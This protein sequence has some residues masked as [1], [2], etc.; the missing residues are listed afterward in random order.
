MVLLFY[1]ECSLLK[2][3]LSTVPLLP[4]AAQETLHS[5]RCEKVLDLGGNL[6]H[7]RQRRIHPRSIRYRSRQ[8]SLDQGS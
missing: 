2:A 4:L 5:L 8:I 1:R 6:D 7:V 3:N